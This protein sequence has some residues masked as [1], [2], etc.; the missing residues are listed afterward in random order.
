M[1]NISQ[2]KYCDLMMRSINRSIIFLH[3]YIKSVLFTLHSKKK[4]FIFQNYLL[5][6]VTEPSV[7]AAEP[8]HHN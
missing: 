1:C 3:K 7:V 5:I 4:K 6:S 2:L 8:Q